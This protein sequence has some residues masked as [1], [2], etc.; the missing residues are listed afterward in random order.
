[1]SKVNFYFE[2]KE[3][4]LSIFDI[5]GDIVAALR[6][7]S[8][9]S[10]LFRIAFFLQKKDVISINIDEENARYVLAENIL[11]YSLADIQKHDAILNPGINYS[12]EYGF[13]FG[14][15]FMDLG[16][17]VLSLTFKLGSNT[18]N[19][20]G[21]LSL[22]K[23]YS[24]DFKWYK[25]ILDSFIQTNS[26]LYASVGPNDIHY[27]EAS[28]K[29]YKYT[30]GWITYFANDLPITIPGDLEGMDFEYID[31]G[32]YLFLSRADFTADQKNYESYIQK[33]LAV[34]EEIIRKESKYLR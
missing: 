18:K 27:L 19:T 1:M 9:Y 13:T 31:K 10:D 2:L 16:K 11:A 26:V 32:K 5:A 8:N 3:K 7:L 24:N 15:L 22:D 28:L 6:I 25:N 23:N 14:L 4:K 29:R 12:R 30:L 34:M 21:T 33:L 20:I 17:K